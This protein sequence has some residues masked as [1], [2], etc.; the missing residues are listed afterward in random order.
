[1]LPWRLSTTASVLASAAS[2][3]AQSGQQSVAACVIKLSS[4][5]DFT[6]LLRQLAQ[7]AC[8]QRIALCSR[9]AMQPRRHHSKFNKGL[10]QCTNFFV[11]GNDA[12]S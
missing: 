6:V 12:C 10:R 8:S 2:L 3:Q 9:E 11:S 7:P 1:M 4:K 5:R